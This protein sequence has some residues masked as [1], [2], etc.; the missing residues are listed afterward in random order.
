LL[1]GMVASGKSSYCRNAARDGWVV[2]NDDAIVNMLHAGDYTLYDKKLKILYKT[3]ENSAVCTALA[4]G[5][6]VLVDRGLNISPRGRS[7]WLSLARSFDIPCEALVF[8][9]EGPTVHAHR[10]AETDSRGHPLE[11]WIR[12]A[13]THNSIYS[14]PT[15]EE[16][17]SAVHTISFKDVQAGRIL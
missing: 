9:N 10:R 15:I 8:E 6:S 17:F 1:C 12:V 11:Y 5:K 16:G 13:E 4:M 3:L 7:R 14:V 2:I